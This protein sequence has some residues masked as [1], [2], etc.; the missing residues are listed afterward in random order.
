MEMLCFLEVT[1]RMP[2]D[3]DGRYKLDGK[4]ALQ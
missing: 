1:N 2:S 3:M 4:V